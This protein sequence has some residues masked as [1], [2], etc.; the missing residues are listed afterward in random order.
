MAE[1]KLT[2]VEQLKM[3]AFRNKADSA[4]RIAELSELIAVG[5]EE[6]SPI[7]ISIILPAANW[8][9]GVQT[10]SHP[11]FLADSRYWYLVCGK[12][13]SADDITADGK[14]VFR[15]EAA[16]ETDLTVHII[17]LEVEI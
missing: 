17:R 12:D 7:G 9:S 10:V 1:K 11:D 6:V 16:P 13:V 14:I 15:C 4:A 8:S 3:L 2:T 5:L